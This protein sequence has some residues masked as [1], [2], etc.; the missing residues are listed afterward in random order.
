MFLIF[1][2]CMPWHLG[3]VISKRLYIFISCPNE[4]LA[5]CANSTSYAAS[6]VEASLAPPPFSFY[7]RALGWGRCLI[8]FAIPFSSLLLQ[9]PRTL[10]NSCQI[11]PPATLTW[12]WYLP[13]RFPSFINDFIALGCPLHSCHHSW[14]L[15]SLIKKSD[16]NNTSLF[17]LCD[18]LVSNN[19]SSPLRLSHTLKL[20]FFTLSSPLSDINPLTLLPLFLYKDTK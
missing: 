4:N 13:T 17:E 3:S 12:E 11:W 1:T 15:N 18:L 6:P 5:V 7:Q 20:V 16:P 19:L 9:H 14:W 2:Y 10:W 8:V